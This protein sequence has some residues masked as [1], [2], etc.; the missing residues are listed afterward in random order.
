MKL[1]STI[2]GIPIKQNVQDEEGDIKIFFT[3]DLSVDVDGSKQSYRLDNDPKLALD[4]IHA[5]AGWPHS[6]WWNVLVRD[7]K[8]PDMPYVDAEGYCVSMTSY[9]RD[10]FSSIDRTRYV[11][12]VSIPYAVIPGIIRKMCEGVLLG[13]AAR[14]TDTLTKEFIDCVCADFS[15]Y[16]IGEASQAA[17]HKF[18]EHLSARNGDERTIYLYE[19]WPDKAAKVADETFRLIPA[20]DPSRHSRHGVA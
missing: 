17:A 3:A 9:E 12:A 6:S 10:G 11:D 2:K 1:L 19:F 5:S 15:G 8:E 20:S 14:I 18:N 4:D 7:P 13:C 16:S